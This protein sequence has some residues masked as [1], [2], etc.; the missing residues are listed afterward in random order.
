MV[1][2]GSVVLQESSVPFQCHNKC[3]REGEWYEPV[4]GGGGTEKRSRKKRGTHIIIPRCCVIRAIQTNNSRFT[5]EQ[6]S[7]DTICNA[8]GVFSIP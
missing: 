4:V 7:N 8:V 6:I 1:G 2:E 5:E 3:L